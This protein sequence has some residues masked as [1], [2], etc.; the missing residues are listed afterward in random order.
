[1]SIKKTIAKTAIII[2]L[3]S[4]IGKALGFIRDM[5]IAGFFGTTFKTDAYFIGLSGPDFIREIIAGGVLTSVFIPVYSSWLAKNDKNKS[6]ELLNTVSSFLIIVLLIAVIIG[7]PLSPYLVKII[8]PEIEGNTF[9]AAV[10]ITKII[11]PSVVF[12]GLASFYGSLLN[13]YKNFVMPACSQIVLNAGIIAGILIFGKRLD[14]QSISLGF[15]AGAVMQLIIVLPQIKS[16]D[17]KFRFMLGWP[18]EI[19]K[20]AYLWI[21]LFIASFAGTANDLVSRALSAGLEPGNVS[22]L[23]FANRIRETVW[24]LCGV[25]LGTVIFPYLSEHAANGENREL[26]NI[27]TFAVSLTV[28]IAL[29]FC[30]IMFFYSKPIISILFERGLFNADSTAMTS[31]ALKYFSI[32]AV[33]FALNFVI[34]RVFY[35]IQDSKNILRALII[36]FIINLVSGY[37]LRKYLFVGGIAL[38]RSLSDSFVFIYLF[39]IISHK[40][41]DFNLSN[42]LK[43]IFKITVSALI[44]VS[45]SYIIFLLFPDTLKILFKIIF[46]SA[47]FLIAVICYVSIGKIWKISE[48]NSVWNIIVKKFN[49]K[50]V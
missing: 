8:A 42:L 40:I 2:T 18:D 29:P 33:F 13:V 41:T 49:I 36:A 5:A 22:A 35:S 26:G 14:I 47:A 32:G 23:N 17:V 45:V 15:L 7:I 31:Y 16:L 44:S 43:N 3:I 27:L 34:M 12:M 46:L 19:K 21:P 37:I 6:E 39:Y 30:I 25:P 28:F 4:I 20:M 48:V 24:L 50:Y 10:K 11:F 38:A 9:I 1:M